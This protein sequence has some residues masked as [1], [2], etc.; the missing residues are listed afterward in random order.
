MFKVISDFPNYMIDM[1]GNVYNSKMIKRKD[2]PN[3]DGYRCVTL[4]DKGYSQS[5]TIHS[6][7]LETYG[8]RYGN[9]CA[10]G[11]NNGQAVLTEDNVLEIKKM[12]KNSKLPQWK[13]GEKFKID[14]STVSNIKTGKL[15][16][17]ICL[18]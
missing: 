5:R 1:D 3:K 10:V 15:W 11:I 7:V 17:H 4:Y 8:Y 9:K 13:I 18:T 16:S 12:L 2:Q 6:L 14:Q